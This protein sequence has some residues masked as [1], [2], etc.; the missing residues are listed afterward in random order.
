[1]T[2]A[3][4]YHRIDQISETKDDPKKLSQVVDRRFHGFEIYIMASLLRS[5]ILTHTHTRTRT[6]ENKNNNKAAKSKGNKQKRARTLTHAA[7]ADEEPRRKK[8]S[9][10][11]LLKSIVSSAAAARVFVCVCARLTHSRSTIRCISF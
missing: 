8:T 11:N 9:F 1:M 6:T 2:A 5:Q 10:K 4:L 7:N 3:V